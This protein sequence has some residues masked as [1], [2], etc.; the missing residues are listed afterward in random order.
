MLLSDIFRRYL[1]ERRGAPPVANQQPLRQHPPAASRQRPQPGAHQQP[2]TGHN[3][4]RP[5]STGRGNAPLIA[6]PNGFQPQNNTI[7]FQPTRNVNPP[8]PNNV[9]NCKCGM[10]SV[11]RTANTA[12]NKGRQFF[13]CPKLQ[14]DPAKCN[15]FQW[16]T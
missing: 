13:A 8:Q 11:I 6:V 12:A 15:F 14:N 2:R 7:Q 4:S 10:P 16:I 1:Q 5:S 9:V 3:G